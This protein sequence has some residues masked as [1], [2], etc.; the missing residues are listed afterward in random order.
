MNHSASPAMRLRLGVRGGP[1]DVQQTV[2]ADAGP[3]VAQRGH[4]GGGQLD[5]VVRVGDDHE[6][7]LGAVALE[8]GDPR[9]HSSIVRGAVDSLVRQRCRAVGRAASYGSA[10]PGHAPH[11]EDGEG[12]DDHGVRAATTRQSG[13]R[14]EPRAGRPGQV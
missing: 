5:G 3:A 1:H 2:A 12:D 11:G 8:E 9:A 4:G 10:E 6:V 7:V 13:R 14:P